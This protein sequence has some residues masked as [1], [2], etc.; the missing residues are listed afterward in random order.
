MTVGETLLGVGNRIPWV[1]DRSMRT[2]VNVG[3][4]ALTL[5]V[6]VGFFAGTFAHWRF[7]VVWLLSATPGALYAGIFGDDKRAD[8][9]Q[10]RGHEAPGAAAATD[11]VDSALNSQPLIVLGGN[12]AILTIGGLFLRYTVLG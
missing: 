5:P 12:Y 11:A 8:M 7:A 10:S 9:V 4:L 2:R 1:R 3:A 6:A